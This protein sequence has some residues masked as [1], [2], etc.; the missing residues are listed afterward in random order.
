MRLNPGAAELVAACK[1]GG[2]DQVLLVSGGFT[3]FTDRIRDQSGH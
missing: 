2:P 1:T 3:F